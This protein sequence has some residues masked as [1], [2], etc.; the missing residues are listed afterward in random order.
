[1]FKLKDGI[2]PL[3]LGFESKDIDY[4]KY[5]EVDGTIRTCFT[6]YKGSP[7]VRYSKTSYVC[8]EQLKLIYEWTK[9]DYIEWEEI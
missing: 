6:I 1:M 4:C 9:L 3:D 7:Y 2:S 5:V 8:E